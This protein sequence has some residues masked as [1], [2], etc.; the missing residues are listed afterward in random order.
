M[1][2][3]LALAQMAYWYFFVSHLAGRPRLQMIIL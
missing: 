3:L 2:A 1:Y